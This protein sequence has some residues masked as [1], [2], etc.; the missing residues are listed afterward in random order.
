[1]RRIKLFAVCCAAVAALA[2]VMVASAA[3]EIPELGRCVKATGETVGKK[4]VYHGN[5]ANKTCLKRKEGRGKY[6]F[7]PGPGPNNKFYGIASEPEPLLET[8]GGIKISCSDVIFK[9]EYTGP[10]SE[11]A[12]L[13]FDGCSEGVN[14][15]CQSNPAKEGEFETTALTGELGTISKSTK[16][17]DVGWDLA[18]EGTLATIECGKLPEIGTPKMI[19]GP[20]V[21]GTVAPGFF[22][23]LDKMS[24]TSIVKY[25]QVAGKQVPESFEGGAKDTLA[26]KGLTA[27]T[28]EQLGFETTEQQNSG[29]GE[30]IES[31]ANEEA[32]EIKAKER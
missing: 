29:L 30:P 32:L 3:A 26:L 28:A 19:E 23:N 1:M 4:T 12:T 6:E 16:K 9:G 2:G 15:P 7:E 21:I 25:V 11:T 20:S 18:H 24:T 8:T 31:E 14:R 22:S 5:F 17:P 27:M 13:R 10:K